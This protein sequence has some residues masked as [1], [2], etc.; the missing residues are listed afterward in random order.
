MSR[1]HRPL[2]LAMVSL[3]PIAVSSAA[4][5]KLVKAASDHFEIYTTDN[6]AAAKAAL[7]HFEI[8]R[9][10]LLQSTN[11]QDPFKTV[12]IFGFKSHGDFGS[13]LPKGVAAEHAFSRGGEDSALI[14]MDGIGKEGYE[15]GMKEYVDLLFE[16]VAPIQN[17][18]ACAKPRCG[19]G[20]CPAP[21]GP[22]QD[23]RAM[24]CH[25]SPSSRASLSAPLRG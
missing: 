3:I 22:L 12:R 16:R 14:L 5:I 19:Q 18:S 7:E 17:V 11:S 8:A 23:T 13:S 6:E 1:L 20:E 4:Q 21:S 15:Y 25:F 10:Y 24:A 2:L 9:A